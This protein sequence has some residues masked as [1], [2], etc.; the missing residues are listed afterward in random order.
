MISTGSRD[1]GARVGR[2]VGDHVIMPGAVISV[3]MVVPRAGRVASDLGMIM[4]V[5]GRCRS[6][7]WIADVVRNRLAGTAI[8]A[9]PHPAGQLSH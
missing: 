1:R 4:L 2:R 7:E 6:G 3:P 5:P 9:V 8:S